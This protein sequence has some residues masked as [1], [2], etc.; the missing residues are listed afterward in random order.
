[1]KTAFALTLAIALVS[2]PAALACDNT[3][4]KD[5]KKTKTVTVNKTKTTQTAV[6][7]EKGGTLLTGSYIKQKVNRSGKITDRGHQVIV[8]DREMIDR[9]G[10]A[11]LKELLVRQGVH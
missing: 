10:A 9:S 11:D 6:T 3:K 1:M 8:L 5:A 7:E 2:T 4:G